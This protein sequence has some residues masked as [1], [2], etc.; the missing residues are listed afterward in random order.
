MFGLFTKNGE[1]LT[2]SFPV[3]KYSG[4]NFIKEH[5]LQELS[6]VKH[7]Y[8]NRERATSNTNLISKL[9]SL[10]IQ[11][12]DLDDYTYAAL[13]KAESRFIAKQLKITNNVS[14]GD[15][16]ENIFYKENSI[17]ILLEVTSDSLLYNLKNT[18]E[19]I[20]PVRCIYTENTDL[21][22][23]QMDGS[24]SLNKLMLSVYEIDTVMLMLQ[25]KY[26]AKFRMESG[27]SINPN[28]FVINYVLPNI[29]SNMLDLTLFNRY[30]A[31]ANNKIIPK[32][33]IGHPFVVSDYS[34]KIDNIFKV[35]VS[36]TD[37]ENIYLE[38]LIMTIPSIVNSNMLYALALH[39]VYYTRQSEWVLWSSRFFYIY[40]LLIALGERGISKNREELY[41]LPA[42]IRQ[43]ENRST[44]IKLPGILMQ[45]LDNKVMEIKRKLGRR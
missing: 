17:E 30:L 31:L 34:D 5:Y 12:I 27:Q 38:Q 23:Y 10:L 32:F 3:K 16:H 44:E 20:V 35:V 4:F 19:E 29:I 1:R 6:K 28:A 43:L 11:N 40:E 25:Y 9:V 45:D 22:F 15:Y 2:H 8:R 36:D 13:V 14:H 37:D 24:K 42:K 39:H 26:W 33:K 18:W 41:E 21:D 7:Y